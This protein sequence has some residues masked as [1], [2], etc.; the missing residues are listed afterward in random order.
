M[1]S[2]LFVL[3]YYIPHR[4]WVENVFE[5]IIKRLDKAWYNIFVLTSKFSPKLADFEEIGNT[6][7]YRVGSGRLSFM[8][9]S[10]WLWK[11]SWEKTKLM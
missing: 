1:K 11:K 9:K 3:D 8:A 2:I 10:I 5:N 4:W 6:K 7:I